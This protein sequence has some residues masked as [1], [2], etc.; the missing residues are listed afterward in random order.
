MSI[1]INGKVYGNIY[2][3]VRIVN[4]KIIPSD[5]NTGK[6]FDER[7]SEDATNIDKIFIESTSA[8]VD[9]ALSDTSEI[10]AHLYGHVNSDAQI[11]LDVRK[12]Y[13][14]L[15]ITVKKKSGFYCGTLK[16]DILV[17]SKMFKEIMI[18][19]ISA[20]I[21]LNANVLTECLKVS[22][23]S[24]D[25]ETNATFD[26]A[27]LNTM[28]GDVDICVDAKRNVAINVSTMSGDVSAEFGNIRKVNLSADTMSGDIQNRHR[29]KEMG[30]IADVNISSMSGDIMIR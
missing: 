14:Q 30:Y 5:G 27:H 6:E 8:N 11:E 1:I 15:R 20:D 9:V 24:G 2:G 22:T 21:T 3:S 26:N 16:L 25:I 19:S 13:R 17:P 18:K 23:R 10:Q 29:E 28:S 4:G 12:A 7:K